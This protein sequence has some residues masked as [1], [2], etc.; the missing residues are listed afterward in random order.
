VLWHENIGR[1]SGAPVTC[2]LDGK[3]FLLVS[4][5][6]ALYAYSLQ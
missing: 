5:G 4:G 3:Q 6:N 1:M 2:E